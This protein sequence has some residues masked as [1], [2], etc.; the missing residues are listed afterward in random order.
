MGSLFPKLVEQPKHIVRQRGA[1]TKVIAKLLGYCL[2]PG[3]VRIT[4]IVVHVRSNLRP[5]VSRN[6]RGP[7]VA[8]STCTVVLARADDVIA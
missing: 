7:N 4:A 8:G 3:L 6:V 1:V 5:V 2:H